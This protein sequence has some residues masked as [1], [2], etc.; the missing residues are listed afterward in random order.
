MKTLCEKLGID[1]TGLVKQIKSD[2]EKITGKEIGDPKIEAIP[3]GASVRG[4][5]RLTLDNSSD[6]ASMVV[7]VLSDPDPAKGVEEVMEK[8]VIKELPFINV[9]KH[10]KKCGV[11]VLD[12]YNYNVEKGLLY[13]EDLGNV[14][15]RNIAEKDDP[16]KRKEAF[17][18]AVVELVK[19]QVDVTKRESDNFLGF[20]AKFDRGL[21]K[22]ELDHFTEYAIEKRFEGSPSSDDKKKID[23]IFNSYVDDLLETKYAVQHRDYHM[24]NLLYKN[25]GFRVIDFQDA[26][27]GPLPYDLAC[28]LYD[29]DTSTILGKDLINHLVG[30]YYD[31]YI[32]KSGDDLDQGSFHRVFDLCVIHR[33]LKVVGR[34]HFIDIVKKRPE[35]LPFNEHMIPVIIDYL[36]RDERGLQLLEIIRK[37]LPEFR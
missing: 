19:I 4:Y 16:E 1:Y 24:D 27:M 2:V 22:W 11:P 23:D 17:E 35:Y 32:R 26:L 7:M 12:I 25:G 21:L 20:H 31:E 8:G 29:R 10:F 34:F 5:A 6:P 13:L 36:G 15:L 18:K 37:Y 3:G 9:Q 30:F 14:H 33:M 28:L